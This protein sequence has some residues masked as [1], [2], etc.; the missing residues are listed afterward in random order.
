MKKGT[1]FPNYSHHVNCNVS[2]NF[3][4]LNILAET[5]LQ[6]FLF[7]IHIIVFLNLFSLLFSFF[8]DAAKE[9]KEERR[10]IPRFHGCSRPMGDLPSS[11]QQVHPPSAD[12][13]NN[14]LQ[15]EVLLWKMQYPW[16][17]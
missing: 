14:A 12:N 10:I 13:C 2:A 4:I 1:I 17:P 15:P 16:I 9:R 5:L 6:L 8:L 3:I 7:E 11:I